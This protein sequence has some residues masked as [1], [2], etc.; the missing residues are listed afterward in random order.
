MGTRRKDRAA[1]IATTLD[2]QISPKIIGTV[3]MPAFL[4]PSISF[5]SLMW[6]PKKNIT[7]TAKASLEGKTETYL[8]GEIRKNPAKTAVKQQRPIIKEEKKGMVLN[9]VGGTL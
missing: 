6:E 5:I 3:L 7:T 8:K 9:L 2:P 4:S 1:I